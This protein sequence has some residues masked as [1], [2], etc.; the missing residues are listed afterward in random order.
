M[1]DN[2]TIVLHVGWTYEGSLT[3]LA[4]PV[5]REISPL[6]RTDGWLHV[7]REIVGKSCGLIIFSLI[8]Q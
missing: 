8:L 2:G 7:W 5:T 3:A 1:Q 6:I 4:T